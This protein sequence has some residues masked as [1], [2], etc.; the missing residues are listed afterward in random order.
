MKALVAYS[1]QSLPLWPIGD[2][3][4]WIAADSA[5]AQLGEVADWWCPRSGGSVIDSM[6]E[7]DRSVKI[8]ASRDDVREIVR[9]D[10]MKMLDHAG[11]MRHE[12]VYVQPRY[13]DWQAM[14]AAA[15]LVL[16]YHLGARE[17]DMVGY[18]G[19]ENEDEQAMGRVLEWMS[20]R[21]VAINMKHVE[22]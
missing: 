11:M 17:I 2:A 8:F 9:R 7:I 10:R 14:P 21:L 19:G 22:Q 12:D 1:G 20:R 15:A 6:W 3:D 4:I 18:D 13:C 16:A 5:I